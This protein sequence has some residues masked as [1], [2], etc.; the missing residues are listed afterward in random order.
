MDKLGL[1]KVSSCYYPRSVTVK[2]VAHHLDTILPDWRNTIDDC[3]S[4]LPFLSVTILEGVRF[5]TGS[6]IRGM[7][8]LPL[9]FQINP[10]SN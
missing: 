1:S 8:F 10:H 3:Y 6:G 7:K 2:R 9:H 4:E 5:H